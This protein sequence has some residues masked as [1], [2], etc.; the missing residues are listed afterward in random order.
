MVRFDF[1]AARITRIE[2]SCGP[3]F[4]APTLLPGWTEE[5]AT[6]HRDW[7]VPTHLHAASNRLI[8]SVH[9]W[10]LE[11]GGRRILIDTCG[12]DDKERPA[13]PGFHRRRTGFL[14]R[15]LAA[16]VRP[17]D[18][19]TVVITH[20]HVDHIGWNTR[21]IDGRWVP[22]FPR[23]RY[24]FPR[25]DFEDLAAQR[26]AADATLWSDSV[27]PVV[28]AG[29]ADLT[30]DTTQLLPGLVIE[31]APGHSPGHG[32]ISLALPDGRTAA[33]CGDV[34]HHPIQFHEPQL[35]SAFCSDADAARRTRTGWLVRWADAGTWVFPGHFAGTFT[36]RVS[37]RDGRFGFRFETPA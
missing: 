4:P 3:G 2:E 14:D 27:A 31:P 19:D 30:Q 37:H 28:D 9:A 12:G 8:L 18:I 24:L 16:G 15:L 21:L 22:T 17:D 7:L 25:A 29:L 20:M 11:F 33:F 1:G 26:T 23:A 32:V 34:A 35:S 5:I 13:L 10:L 36:G 6:R